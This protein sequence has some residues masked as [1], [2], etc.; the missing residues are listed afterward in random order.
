M[1]TNVSPKM[2][3][4]L[5]L[6]GIDGFTGTNPKHE[7]QEDALLALTVT[8]SSTTAVTTTT[9]TTVDLDGSNAYNV[10]K[11]DILLI[12]SE[13]VWVNTIESAS[14]IGVIRAAFGTTAAT[15]ATASTMT[16][17][18]STLDELTDSPLA[19][20]TVHTFPFNYFSI[21]DKLIRISHRAQ[22]TAE[23]NIDDRLDYEVDKKLKEALV[24]LARQVF[25]GVRNVGTGATDP[26]NMGG[27]K[28]FITNNTD[29][30]AEALTEKKINDLLALCFADVGHENLPDT[31]AVG[32]WQ[33]RKITSFYEPMARMDRATRTGGVVVDVIDT[34][35]GEID[36][37]LEFNMQTDHL[38]L[39]KR[40]LI[41][42]GSFKN[43]AF[44]DEPLPSDGAYTNHHIYGDY[45]LEVHADTAHGYMSGLTTS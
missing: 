5:K 4:F 2:V 30:T 11:G 43:S 33:K 3:P 15:H 20:T 12:D 25:Y 9:I 14:N 16:R 24:D 1:I 7:W 39:V 45:S 6:I 31:I 37:V 34:E 40:D 44:F 38:F 13:Q 28:T 35:F 21:F 26:P 29:T 42:V 36:V 27:L 18:G 19:G 17:V 10:S 8:V 41:K 22:N 32:Q 23:Y